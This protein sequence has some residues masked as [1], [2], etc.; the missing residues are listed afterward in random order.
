MTPFTLQDKL[1]AW[2]SLSKTVLGIT[3]AVL[4]TLLANATSISGASPG[5]WPPQPPRSVSTHTTITPTLLTSYIANPGIGWQ[6]VS[7]P[8]QPVLTETVAYRRAQLPYGWKIFNPAENVYDFSALDADLSAAVALGKQFSFR[9]YTMRG[10]EYGGH[11]VPQWVID[12][13]AVILE[14]GEPDYSDC[15]YQ[16]E[17]A[18]FVE[19]LR[20]RYDGNADLAFIDIS[21]YGNFNEWSWQDQT[22]WDDD[23]MN[24]T[25]LDG[26]ARKR[27]ADLFIGGASATHQCRNASG[28]TKTAPY[29]YPGFQTTQLVMPYAGVQ[30]STR[31][32]AARR[33]DVG[34]RHDSLGSYDYT[35]KP[36]AMLDKIGDVITNTWRQAPIVYEFSSRS[37]TI[38]NADAMLKATHGSIVHDNP[39]G[40]ASISASQ[41]GDLLRYVGYRFIVRQ[42]EIPPT[43]TVPGNLNVSLSWNNLGYAPAYPRMGQV[44]QAHFYLAGKG[45]TIASDWSLTAN[46]ADWLPAHPYAATPPDY[47]I[48]QTLTLPALPSGTYTACVALVDQRTLQSIHLGIA[49]RDAQGHYPLG[50]ITVTSSGVS[51]RAF[52]PLLLKDSPSWQAKRN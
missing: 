4:V 9:V 22:S 40:T 15:V 38:S 48:H 30:Q 24:P 50:S 28:Q 3:L 45:G 7:D 25:T 51:Y 27:L 42:A 19:Q 2:G 6:E 35:L 39:G 21:G 41:M 29:S 10:E 44:L 46:V 33:S 17:W 32:V 31:Y 47:T 11:Q 23:Y 1:V 43:A 20:Q 49:G 12:K 14:T 8:T 26:L 18:R 34:I 36:G 13:G 52:L 5:A 37:T 16:A